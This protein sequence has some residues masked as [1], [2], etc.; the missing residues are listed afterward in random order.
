DVPVFP[1]QMQGKIRDPLAQK[2]FDYWFSLVMLDKWL[3]LP[4][5]T[6]D[7]IVQAYRDAFNRAIKDAEFLDRGR[8]ISEDFEPQSASDVKGL[9]DTLGSTPAEAFDYINDMLKRQGIGAT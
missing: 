2:G 1:A 7:P 5:G 9:I 4:A 3:V 6:P 8:K